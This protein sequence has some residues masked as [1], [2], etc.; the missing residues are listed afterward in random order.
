MGKEIFIISD[1]HFGHAGMLNF[2]NYD[3]TRMRPFSYVEEM[4]EFII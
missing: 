2:L 3:G 1:T 4:Y